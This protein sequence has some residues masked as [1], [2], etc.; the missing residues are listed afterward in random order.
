MRVAGAPLK[1]LAVSVSFPTRVTMIALRVFRSISFTVVSVSVNLSVPSVVA[2]LWA[3]TF[4][5]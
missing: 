5:L 3:R 4:V 1:M 2:D